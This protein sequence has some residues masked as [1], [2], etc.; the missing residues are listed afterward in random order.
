[1][2]V[3]KG[4]SPKQYWKGRNTIY[5]KSRKVC[6]DCFSVTN[7]FDVC[8][9]NLL[10]ENSAREADCLANGGRHKAVVQ[11]GLFKPETQA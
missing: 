2:N 9:K 1:M 5:P 7:N 10:H 4:F 8:V 11:P 3:T 6:E